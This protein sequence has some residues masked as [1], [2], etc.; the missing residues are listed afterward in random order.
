MDKD[1]LIDCIENEGESS[2]IDFK[3]DI[4][5]FKN[6]KSKAEL[7]KDILCFAN[8]HSVGDKYIITGVKLYRDNTRDFRGITDDKI[9][10]GADYQN[11]IDEHIEPSLIVDFLPLKYKE[12]IFGVFKIGKENNDRPYLLK[13]K[14]ENYEE[15]FIK[16][17]IGQRNANIT[18]RDLDKMYS[19]KIKEEK[20]NIL[21]KGIVD[22]NIS[23]KFK[24]NK[25]KDNLFSDENILVL[26]NKIEKLILKAKK[27]KL[28]KYA[29]GGLLSGLYERVEFDNDTIDYIKSYATL[30]KL[31]LGDDFF[32]LGTLGSINLGLT[33]SLN[34]TDDEISKYKI[35]NEVFEYVMQY[36]ALITFRNEMDNIYYI[37]LLLENNGN[38]YDDDIQL[39]L[40]ISQKDF[41]NFLDFPR[42]KRGIVKKITK[43]D[44]LEKWFNI[45]PYKN[46][47]CHN[48]NNTKVSKA[49]LPSKHRSGL[50]GYYFLP[51]SKEYLDYY[52]D[53]IESL[54]DYNISYSDGFYYI[55]TVQKSIS[56]NEKVFLPSRLFVTKNIDFIEYEIISKYNSE[57]IVGKICGIKS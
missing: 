16:I 15:G 6:T 23:D 5:D 8:G 27:L 3:S 36:Y 33:N 11:F 53:K 22:E 25:L 38:H 1:Y 30:K 54:I 42:P 51:D 47:N 9:M 17:R 21:L 41:I 49:I 31:T 29:D 40:K 46:I 20:S 14:Y 2:Y 48:G 13:K 45:E 52:S 50:P 18:R 10:D 12:L 24:I 32:N 7:L 28:K 34:G 43:E 26:E 19:S 56:P 37:E 35:V 57:K 4:Y 39:T 44:Y 55:R